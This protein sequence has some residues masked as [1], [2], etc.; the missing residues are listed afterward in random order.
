MRRVICLSACL[1]IGLAAAAD[2]AD[3][4]IGARQFYNAI[5]VR[6]GCM[7]LVPPG[8]DRYRHAMPACGCKQVV[9]PGRKRLL[10]FG[11]AHADSPV[12]TTPLSVQL[13]GPVCDVPQ[14]QP[15]AE[16]NASTTESWSPSLADQPVAE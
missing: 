8:S 4:W 15:M 2:G 11:R 14:M 9:R 13:R 6:C 1:F 12:G 16:P 7:Q 5:S 10:T 3:I